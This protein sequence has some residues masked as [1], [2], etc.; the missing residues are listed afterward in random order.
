MT[1]RGIQTLPSVEQKSGHTAHTQQSL[2]AS[3]PVFI[4]WGLKVIELAFQS[5]VP[6]LTVV[7]SLWWVSAFLQGVGHLFGICFIVQNL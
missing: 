6:C 1:T 4:S 3:I 5:L 7:W 2:V